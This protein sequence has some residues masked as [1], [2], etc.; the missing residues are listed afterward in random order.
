L[1]KD[2]DRSAVV[3]RAVADEAAGVATVALG[4]GGGLTTLTTGTA[5]AA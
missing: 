4:A 1:P 3:Q 2:T 5:Q